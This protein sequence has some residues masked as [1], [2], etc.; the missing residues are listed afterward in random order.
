[1]RSAL[2]LLVF[3]A[4]AAYL[5]WTFGGAP[6][7]VYALLFTRSVFGFARAL[8]GEPATPRIQAE[9]CPRQ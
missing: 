1:M 3:A 5:V 7:W 6:W 8:I 2:W 4:I 9:P